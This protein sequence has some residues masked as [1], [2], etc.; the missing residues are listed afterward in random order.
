[1]TREPLLLSGVPSAIQSYG[2]AVLSVAIALG[3]GLFL[4]DFNIQ[5]VAFPLFLIA[6]SRDGQPQSWR[7]API[8]TARGK[9][10]M[11]PVVVLTSSRVE[12]DMVRS[13]RLGVKA[14]VVK[15][16]ISTSL[17]TLSRN[18]VSFGRVSMNHHHLGA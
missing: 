8:P 15:P 12:R 7:P 14:Y 10:K 11:I 6:T 9:L 4:V 16:S 2:L 1:M 13:Y 17:L 3:I 5:G 18:S